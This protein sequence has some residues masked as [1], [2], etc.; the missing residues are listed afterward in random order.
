MPEIAAAGLGSGLDVRSLVD[1]L[2]SAERTPLNNRLNLQEAR[3]NQELSSIGKV[4]AALST[5]GD[6]LEKL[7]GDSAFNQR[8]T[9]VEEP[10]LLAVTATSDAAAGS[11]SLEVIALATRQ[12]TA[13]SAFVDSD[14][15]VGWGTLSFTIDG[16][17]FDVDI[18]DG[19]GSLVEIRDAVNEVAAESGI[20]ASIVTADDGA[21]IVFTSEGTGTD[22]AFSISSSGGDG[23][24]AVLDYSTS[25][26]GAMTEVTLAADAE[27]TIDGF[28]V[29]SSDNQIADA[30]EGVTFSL[31]EADPGNVFTVE[32]ELDRASTRATLE[33]F[34]AAYNGVITTIKG[35]TAFDADAGVAGVL[36]GDSTVRGIQESLRRELSRVINDSS[37]TFTTLSQLGIQT[38]IDGKLEID[39]GVL[40]SAVAEDFDAIASLFNSPSGV[41]TRMNDLVATI[42]GTDGQIEGREER[43]RTELEGIGEDR[44]RLDTRM[45]SVRARLEAQFNAMDQLIAQLNTTS[46]FLAQQLGGLA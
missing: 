20:V 7:A 21:R 29:T 37:L 17:T 22:N 31:L 39:G 26:P 2:V 19:A 38:T 46:Q 14:T 18:A 25:V 42:L 44:E 13:S 33:Q 24:L 36:L 6:T 45:Q 11:Y 43:L 15:A 9:S 5:L 10:D 12:K 16:A 8:T 40:D 34:V 32:I 23:G 30:V 1:Q 27:V 28:S 3:A 4:K 41:A 35:E